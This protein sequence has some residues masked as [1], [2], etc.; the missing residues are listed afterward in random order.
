M[1]SRVASHH[2]EHNVR[3]LSIV[4]ASTD[5]AH[6]RIAIE[7]PDVHLRN[8][9]LLGFYAEMLEKG[10][11]RFSKDAYEE[12]IESLGADVDISAG[13]NMVHLSVTSRAVNLARVLAVLKATLEAPRM[14]PREIVKLKKEYIQGFHELKNDTRHLAFALFSRALYAETDVEYIPTLTER[15]ELLTSLTRKDLVDIHRLI[16]GGKWHMTVAGAKKT[17]HEAQRFVEYFVAKKA[18]V[19]HEREE[20]VLPV[21]PER[22]CEPVLGKQNIELYIGNHVPLL[23]TDPEY[24]AL[25]FGI[26]VLGKR[27]GFAGRLMSTVREK[28]GLTYSIYSWLSGAD[29]V[30]SGHAVIWTFFT[31]KDIEKGLT[32][33]MREVRK[34]VSGGVKD[35]EMTQFKTLL[36]NQFTLTFESVKG[37]VA[38]YHGALLRGLSP[39]FVESYPERVDALTKAE[40]NR[41]LKA[42]FDP[43]AFVIAGAGTLEKLP[44]VA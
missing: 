11:K 25:A 28:E 12:T 20:R 40:V 35:T 26:D 15:E 19:H 1:K 27:G 36:S 3:M 31:P 7:L 21:P 10:S 37:M 30:R 39:E 29:A 13:G 32:S 4:P 6:V 24:S 5:V 43:N 9:I 38:L 14:S 2:V 23:P 17:M 44:K 34:L 41:A 33:T 22:L 8:K 18:P 16:S 42:H